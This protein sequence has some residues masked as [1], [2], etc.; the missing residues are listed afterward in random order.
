MLKKLRQEISE[1]LELP[2]DVGMDLPKV[3]IIG[4]LGVLIQNHRGLI[5]Y[6]PEKIVI[7]VGKGQIAILGKSLEIEEVSK[8]DMIVR[9]LL[10]SVQ[11]E[12]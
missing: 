3:T 12:T 9:G 4:N 11:M 1:I 2:L 6:S 8:E 5:Q 7:G 10:G